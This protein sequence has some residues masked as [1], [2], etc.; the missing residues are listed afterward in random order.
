MADSDSHITHTHARTP[1]RSSKQTHVL[2]CQ[3]LM[4]QIFKLRTPPETDAIASESRHSRT[5]GKERLQMRV[6]SVDARTPRTKP[7]SRLPLSPFHLSSRHAL[8]KYR[9]RLSHFPPLR[10]SSLACQLL[11]LLR[12]DQTYACPSPTRLRTFSTPSQPTPAAATSW[13]NK[14]S[15]SPRR[16]PLLTGVPS[17]GSPSPEREC[18]QAIFNPPVVQQLTSV[19]RWM[20]QFSTFGYFLVPPV[21]FSR[22]LTPLDSRSYLN[23]FGVYQGTLS[24]RPRT[25]SSHPRRLLHSRLSVPR[26]SIQHQV[27]CLPRSP[28]TDPV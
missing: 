23:A 21:P 11:S 28:M 15:T 9:R 17:P 27:R 20:I 16:L 18:P 12:P 5:E 4:S 14:T 10:L 22:P 3:G 25:P 2:A 19:T 6:R 26:V 24:R 8:L 13:R 7:G 1:F